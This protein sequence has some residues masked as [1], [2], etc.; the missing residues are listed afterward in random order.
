MTPETTRDGHIVLARKRSY[1]LADLLA[2]CQT[3][4]APPADLE[5]WDADRPMGQELW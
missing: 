2:Q 5:P 1:T 4:A 3:E